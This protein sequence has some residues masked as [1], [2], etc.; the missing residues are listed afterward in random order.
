MRVG[1]LGTRA[2]LMDHNLWAPGS[3]AGRPD[4]EGVPG[5]VGG[6]ALD[7]GRRR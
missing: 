6:P 2:A 3:R 5:Y 4:E 7:A 1:Q